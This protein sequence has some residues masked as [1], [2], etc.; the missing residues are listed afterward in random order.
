MRAVIT[1][2]VLVVAVLFVLVLLLPSKRDTSV[3]VWWFRVRRQTDIAARVVLVLAVVGGTVWFV[4]LP[5][6]D[7]LSIG[8]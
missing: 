2:I 1:T 8:R 3:A 5:L 6:L 7:W 4:V